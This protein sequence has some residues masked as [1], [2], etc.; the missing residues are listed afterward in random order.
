M[1]TEMKPATRV[2]VPITAQER[3]EIEVAMKYYGIR[4]MAEY[5]RF[6]GLRVARQGS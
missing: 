5:L 3:A 4:A 6:A 2:P 1:Q